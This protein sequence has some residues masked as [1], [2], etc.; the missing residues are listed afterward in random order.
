[1]VSLDNVTK[2]AVSCEFGHILKISLMENFIFCA[3]ENIS[4]FVFTYKVKR[5]TVASFL[6]SLVFLFS[7][8]T[9]YTLR[10]KKLRRRLM[11]NCQGRMFIVALCSVFPVGKDD[12]GIGNA[13]CSLNL[14]TKKQEACRGAVPVFNKEP[15]MSPPSF[16]TPVTICSSLCSLLTHSTRAKLNLSA[17]FV[18]KCNACPW[19]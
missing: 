16:G 5:F 9:C 13:F 7:C 1:M 2:S 19:C 8:V 3:V 11:Q 6:G 15:T 18:P 17:L 10:I 12:V 14:S 4:H